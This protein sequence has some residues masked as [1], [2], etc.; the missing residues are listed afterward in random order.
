MQC[1]PLHA[2]HCATPPRTATHVTYY[3]LRSWVLWQRQL[4]RAESQRGQ[5]QQLPKRTRLPHGHVHNL[6]P[7]PTS[8]TAH[9]RAATT[10][11]TTIATPAEE[12]RR[13]SRTARRRTAPPSPRKGGGRSTSKTRQPEAKRN[14]QSVPRRH[15]KKRTGEE[16]RAT[17]ATAPAPETVVT[18]PGV[19]TR[20]PL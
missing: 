14:A 17:V 3:A 8:T 12:S 15:A 13:V 6:P 18:S 2:Q 10:R 9:A 20:R 1:A 11:T 7:R 19:G 5:R 16:A 4:L